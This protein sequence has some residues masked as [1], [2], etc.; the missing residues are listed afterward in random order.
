VRPGE[1]L[2]YLVLGA[3]REGNRMLAASLKPSASRPPG[4]KPSRAGEREPL[5]ISELGNLLVCQVDQPQPTGHQNDH[6]RTAH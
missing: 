4:P 1:Q 3:Q 5:T 2:R 6:R